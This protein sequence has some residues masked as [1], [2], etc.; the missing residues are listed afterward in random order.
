MKMDRSR[1]AMMPD[2][3]RIV[4]KT[5]GAQRTLERIVQHV[6]QKMGVDVCSV[7]A[8]NGE[9]A[10]LTLQA[11]AG[12]DEDSA[13]RVGMRVQEGLTGL[14]LEKQEPVFV[15]HPK[16]HPRHKFSAESGEDIFETFLGIPLVYQHDVLGVLVIRTVEED[17]IP[18]ADIPV[19]STVA[20]QIATI[21]G[22][23]GL[24]EDF[25]EGARGQAFGRSLQ[26]EKTGPR[27]KEAKALL[28]GIPVSPGFGEGYA[29]FIG[30]TIGFDQVEERRVDDTASEIARIDDALRRARSEIRRLGKKIEGLSEQD[31]SILG[32][33]LMYLEDFSFKEKVL[34]RIREGYCAEYALKK[35]VME[36][37]DFFEHMDD[38]Y[39]RERAFD[40]EDM[41]K[42][43][44]RNLLGLE[45]QLPKVFSRDTILVAS[46]I[47]VRELI[48]LRQENL[49]GLV[50]SCGGKT[51]HTTILAKSFEIPMVIG[52]ADVLESVK[53]GDFLILDGRLGLV[54]NRPI[55]VIIDEY[56]RLKT[57]KDKQLKQLE[58]LKNLRA[59]TR[60]GYEVRVGANVGLVSD[61]DLTEKYGADHIGLFRTEIPFL[62]R[63]EFPSEEEQLE[64]Y[65][66]MLRGAGQRSVTI[67]TLD[68]GG[69]KFLS[70]LDYPKENNPS[71]GWRSIRVSLEIE[72]VFRTQVRAVLKA[73]A[74]GKLKILFPMITSVEEVKRIS[75]I[76]EEEQRLLDRQ[77]ISFDRDMPKGIMVEVPGTVRILDR[78]LRYVDFVSIGTND[79]IQYTLAV[80]R[81]NQKVAA[82]Y[83]PLHPAVISTVFEAVSTCK[84]MNKEVSICGETTSLPPCAYLFLGMEV[85]RLSMNSGSIPTIKRLIRS[86]NLANAKESLKSVLLMESAEDIRRFLDRVLPPI[87]IFWSIP[88]E[89]I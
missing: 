69:D 37:V 78:L 30:K 71:L 40:I 6:V 15:V 41:G 26:E 58:T 42:G 82:L 83:N 18:E 51:S 21:L 75:C 54:F 43:L 88:P 62:A 10:C 80:D 84:E 25:K 45:V 20:N 7:Y 1:I 85:D 12:L 50:L 38:P 52:L 87:P 34:A 57:E 86:V 76:L 27:R 66:K 32:A 53:D 47:S 72:D 8:L 64:L 68:V 60:D 29:Y 65:K 11:T 48:G 2:L 31:Q 77:G 74:F 13:G 19:L 36:Y 28:R 24:L 17:A 4:C 22:Y 67:R 44:L 63:T 35:V 3:C 55:Q 9:K 56:A 14:V 89:F 39:L 59:V 73:S 81:S 23:T 33:Q 49:K 70:Y 61:L 46:D 5:G 16:K 79:L